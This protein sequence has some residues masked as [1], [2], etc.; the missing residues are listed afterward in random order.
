[1]RAVRPVV[2]IAMSPKFAAPPRGEP[3]VERARLARVGRQRPRDE[4]VEGPL[5][6]RVV[7]NELG[8][9]H[10]GG[11]HHQVLHAA[12]A[13]GPQDA[14]TLDREAGAVLLRH[15]PGAGIAPGVV[16]G[17]AG[18]HRERHG[19]DHDLPHRGRLGHRVHQPATLSG[20]EHG[21][22]RPVDRGI[23]AAVLP[24]VDDEDLEQ[25]TPAE[26]AIEAAGLLARRPDREVVDEGAPPRLHQGLGGSGEVV[27]D[28]VVVPDRVHRRAA[29][30]C[31]HRR[32]LAVVAMLGPEVG[33][34]PRH[35]VVTGHVLRLAAH[36]VGVDGVAHEEK[37]IGGCLR[38]SA[39]DR[40]SD[41][42][43]AAVPAAAEIAAPGEAHRPRV[44]RRRGGHELA[45]GLGRVLGRGVA[46]ARAR[47]ERLEQELAGQVAARLHPDLAAGA[48]GRLARCA[49][50]AAEGLVAHADLAPG[51]AAHPH[52]RGGVGHL[53]HRDQ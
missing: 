30:V 29:E 39:E 14:V 45:G 33:Q 37:E 35:E 22:A 3:G 34:A 31:L 9:V 2:S 23:G 21:L 32:I 48:G 1:M 43:L 6:R 49:R 42:G 36:V 26:L 11:E 8:V 19:R 24:R 52:H 7:A 12:L 51:D 18:G 15:A 38:E 13:Q 27:A 10:V 40:V 16:G 44:G 50:R 41:A 5:G 47:F 28:L 46:V 20:A 25:R 53:A 4:F 17:A